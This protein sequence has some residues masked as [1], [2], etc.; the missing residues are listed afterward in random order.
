MAGLV[1]RNTIVAVMIAIAFWTTCFLIGT[2]KSSMENTIRRYRIARIVPAGDEV[3]CADELNTLL[4]W[5]EESR[6]WKALF[7]GQEQEQ[8]RMALIVVPE[9]L[10]RFPP[11]MAG[12]VYDEKNQQIATATISFKALGRPALFSAKKGEKGWKLTEGPPAPGQPIALLHRPGNPPLLVAAGSI[13]QILRGADSS[14]PKLRLPGFTIPL[15]GRESVS[16]VTPDPAPYW[17]AP[18][19]A[20]LD[21]QS[22]TLA[23]YS[24]GTVQLLG[25]DKTARR[26]KLLVEKKLSI[27]EAEPAVVALGGG[28]CG[29]FRKDGTALLLDAKT[30]ETR[31]ELD[32]ATESPPRTAL[33]SPDGRWLAVL[34]HDGRL[35]LIDTKDDSV[36]SPAVKGQGDISAIAFDPEGKLLVADRATRVTRYELAPLKAVQTIAARLD[37]QERGYYYGAKPLY[38]VL[39]KPGEFYKTVQYLLTKQETSAKETGELTAAQTKLNPWSP[40]WSS[41]L[42]TAVMLGLG[43]IYMSRQEF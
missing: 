43:C 34:L 9:L 12:P 8:V 4:R 41:A 35:R 17:G 21:G 39:P 36:E 29:V 33:A 6:T 1:W 2:A 37:F 11:P 16:D 23:V 7:A 28:T 10:F 13:H 15:G 40:V 5:D 26:F 42:F 19:S 22:R 3:L 20:A 27:D 18:S 38:L 32:L 31:R 14:G 24:R 25:D 30:L